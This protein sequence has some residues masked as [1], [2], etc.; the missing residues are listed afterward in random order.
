M[1]KIIL[2]IVCLCAIGSFFSCSNDDNGPA[3]AP[4]AAN[5]ITYDKVPGAIIIRLNKPAEPRLL[6]K[7]QEKTNH[8][9]VWLVPMQI[10]SR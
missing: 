2:S 8:V 3:P 1:K 7:Y 5:A 4:L 6:I 9:C 10:L